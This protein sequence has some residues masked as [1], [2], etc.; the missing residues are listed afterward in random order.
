[1]RLRDPAYTRIL[2]ATLPETTPVSEAAHLQEDLRRAGIEPWA[3]LI[4]HSLLAT[5]SRDPLLRARMS[6]E[7]EQVERVARECA[8]LVPVPAGPRSRS[9]WSGSA[10]SLRTR[11]SSPRAPLSEP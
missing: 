3:W 7:A 9:G 2:L 8:R 10:H 11:A 4:N 1:M 5:G 6:A